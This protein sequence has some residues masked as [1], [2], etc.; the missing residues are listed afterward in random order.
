MRRRVVRRN[1]IQ[2]PFVAKLKHDFEFD[3]EFN[4][5]NKLRFFNDELLNHEIAFNYSTFCPVL[6]FFT[7]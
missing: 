5:R 4:A 1:I 6:I 7:N 2:V 3:L